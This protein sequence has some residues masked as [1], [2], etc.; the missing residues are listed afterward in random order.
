M[1]EWKKKTGK[2]NDNHVR[3]TILYRQMFSLNVFQASGCIQIKYRLSREKK[4][5]TSFNLI[6]KWFAKFTP[7]G[8]INCHLMTFT[9][10]ILEILLLN[11]KKLFPINCSCYVNVEKNCNLKHMCFLHM[12]HFKYSSFLNCVHLSIHII[13]IIVNANKSN[14]KLFWF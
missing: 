1:K 10:L 2:I 3:E 5:I 7:E 8:V 13:K 9:Y 6:L 11:K 4:N 12:C 14:T